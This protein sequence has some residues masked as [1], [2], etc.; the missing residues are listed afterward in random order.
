MKAYTLMQSFASGV[1]SLLS[2][3]VQ[4]MTKSSEATASIEASD[5]DSR[6]SNENDGVDSSSS[7]LEDNRDIVHA[8]AASTIRNQT[9]RAGKE[10]V[11]VEPQTRA[12]PKASTSAQPTAIQSPSTAQAEARISAHPTDIQA[13][14]TVQPEA[15]SCAHPTAM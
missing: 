13:P 3:F 15:S 4:G 10:P 5:D 6:V 9:R 8:A 1:N 7:E 11:T 12:H 2:T 14:T